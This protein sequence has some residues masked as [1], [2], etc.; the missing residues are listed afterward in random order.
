MF[1]SGNV[2][3]IRQVWGC[4]VKK[5]R[6]EALLSGKKRARY[7]GIRNVSWRHVNHHRLGEVNSYVAWV[8]LIGDF[9]QPSMEAILIYGVPRTV[10]SVWDSES[11]GRSSGVYPPEF[12]MDK[13]NFIGNKGI[14]FSYKLLNLKRP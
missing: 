11:K 13:V 8:G 10:N 1:V 14:I 4:G 9:G 2:E 6:M 7:F 5:A 12:S 3:F